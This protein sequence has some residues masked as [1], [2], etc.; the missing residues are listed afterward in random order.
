MFL[1]GVK[2]IK[3]NKLKFINNIFD[4]FNDFVEVWFN[5]Y[6]T[7]FRDP[8]VIMLF[9]I[10]ILIYPLIYSIAY[11]TELSKEVPITIVDN[12]NSEYSRKLI[13]MLDATD[14][15]KVLNVTSNFELAKEEFKKQDINGIIKIPKD[16][17]N[18][19]LG[20]QSANVIVYADAS[21]ML[22]YKQ[23]A[24]AANMAIGT[25]SAGIEI[26]RRTAQ[27]E[28]LE[29]SMIERDPL[30]LEVYSLYNPRGGYATYILPAL[31]IMMLQQTLFLGIGLLGGTFKERSLGEFLTRIGKKKSG[32]LSIVMGKSMAYYT[33]YLIN[34]AFIFVIVSSIFKLPMRGS[35]FEVF[36][37]LTPFIFASIF[38][39]LTMSTFFK[40]R[41]H[42]LMILLFTSIPIIF[43]SG[44][45]WPLDAMP[46]WQV[47]LAQILPSTPGINGYLTLTQKG[48]DFSYITGNLQHL[49][50]LIIIYLISAT[51]L[52]RR[53]LRK[54]D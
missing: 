42:A 18:K 9:L 29:K 49:G 23:I 45:S 12:D 31:F 5:E 54:E 44:F 3:H 47:W 46:Q 40:R 10:A 13:S 17:D 48:G 19:I 25:Y 21:Y 37:L 4:W 16:F 1:I 8:G 43:L 53:I 30:P 24:T 7:V 33:I 51:L 28:T 41:E 36:L 6:K 34:S 35:Y 52:F 27:G 20:F 22:I 39:G 2:N 11:N 15:I 14:E 32:P 38:M 50:I 26:T